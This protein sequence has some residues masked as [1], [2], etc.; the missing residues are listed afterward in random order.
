[1]VKA[2]L[3]AGP[4]A[5]RPDEGGCARLDFDVTF[6]GD[7]PGGLY[8]LVVVGAIAFTPFLAAH[9][10]TVDRDCRAPRADHGGGS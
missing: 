1:V 4:L 7:C 8:S 6:A 9:Y 2:T 10:V 3:A 5:C